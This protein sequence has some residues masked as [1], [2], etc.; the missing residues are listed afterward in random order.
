LQY[1][2]FS[3]TYLT[4]HPLEKNQ[5]NNN[6]QTRAFGKYCFRPRTIGQ[7]RYSILSR[8][9]ITFLANTNP[10]RRRPET[11]LKFIATQLY[12]FSVLH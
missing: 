10:T 7:L 2:I 9:V 8:T 4:F 12:V 6:R 5:A 11:K 3:T 1:S